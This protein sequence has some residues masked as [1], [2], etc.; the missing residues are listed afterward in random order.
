MV[1]PLII[2]ELSSGN[3]AFSMISV[4]QLIILILILGQTSEAQLANS[5]DVCG[6]VIC[7]FVFSLTHCWYV[8]PNATMSPF[9]CD[10]ALNPTQFLLSSNSLNRLRVL[11]LK[12]LASTI[13]SEVFLGYNN[14]GVEIHEFTKTI[15]QED[16]YCIFTMIHAI[17]Y[18]NKWF[19]LKTI[20]VIFVMN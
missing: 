20:T 4:E 2:K 9:P 8:T 18:K 19:L 11:L 5:N 1:L 17:R 16:Q 6:S 10:D 12:V 7:A 3:F 14:V 15:F 13:T